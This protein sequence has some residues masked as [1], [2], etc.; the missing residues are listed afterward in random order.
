[1]AKRNLISLD[2]SSG[3]IAMRLSDTPSSGWYF[4]P[5]QASVDVSSAST[6]H[7]PLE[8]AKGVAALTSF[9]PGGDSDVEDLRAVALALD[10]LLSATKPELAH[11]LTELLP[12][13]DFAERRARRR[14]EAENGG[15]RADSVSVRR[16]ALC[17]QFGVL[18]AMRV[19][20]VDASPTGDHGGV[21]DHALLFGRDMN[22]ARFQ[23][24]S[25]LAEAVA[26]AS[27]PL[28]S[29]AFPSFDAQAAQDWAVLVEACLARPST[30][31][32]KDTLQRLASS[33]DALGKSRGARAAIA[34]LLSANASLATAYATTFCFLL[35]PLLTIMSDSSK[36]DFGEI[37]ATASPPSLNELV[38]RFVSQRTILLFEHHYSFGA[39]ARMLFFRLVQGVKRPR[40]RV[41]LKWVRSFHAV[42]LDLSWRRSLLTFSERSALKDNSGGCGDAFLAL[43][44]RVAARLT[45]VEA[46]DSAPV[47]D[48]M[49]FVTSISS[50]L[51]LGLICVGSDVQIATSESN[52]VALSDSIYPLLAT[53]LD[54]FLASLALQ[55]L[56]ASVSSASGFGAASGFER[57]STRPL[58]EFPSLQSKS[59][60]LLSRTLQL[61]GAKE[62]LGQRALQLKGRLSESLS[63]LPANVD[64]LL[65]AAAYAPDIVGAG[66]G[67]VAAAGAAIEESGRADES[68]EGSRLSRSV[69]DAC[70]IIRRV[71]I[72]FSGQGGGG[73]DF[74]PPEKI[75]FNDYLFDTTR[76]SCK[77]Q[78]RPEREDVSLVPDDA[79]ID[80]LWQPISSIG[81][82]KVVVAR[83]IFEIL[84]DSD[85]PH[86]HSASEASDRRQF[87]LYVAHPLSS[88]DVRS[89]STALLILR[90]FL[91]DADTVKDLELR[92]DEARV[93]LHEARKRATFGEADYLQSI[94]VSARN[95]YALDATLLAYAL[96]ARTLRQSDV[97]LL[98][99]H[100]V[101]S[102][103]LGEESGINGSRSAEAVCMALAW[104]LQGIE[105]VGLS[106]TQSRTDHCFGET[107]WAVSS[108]SD[109]SIPFKTSRAANEFK[110]L[111]G[112]SGQSVCGQ[113]SSRPSLH[114]LGQTLLSCHDFVKVLHGPHSSF[115]T[116]VR[117]EAQLLLSGLSHPAVSA[118]VIHSFKSLLASPEFL[119]ASAEAASVGGAG[120]GATLLADRLPPI[121]RSASALA[122]RFPAQLSC[123][124]LS[125]ARVALLLLFPPRSSGGINCVRHVT[126]TSSAAVLNFG[127]SPPLLTNYKPSVSLSAPIEAVADLLSDLVILAGAGVTSEVNSSSSG[128][129]TFGVSVVRFV[130]IVCARNGGEAGK[131][132]AR[133]VLTRLALCLHCLPMMSDAST[134]R[135]SQLSPT[136]SGWRDSRVT[137]LAPRQS[138]AVARAM[139]S[140]TPSVSLELSAALCELVVEALAASERAFEI[141][142]AALKSRGRESIVEGAS[143][144]PPSTKLRALLSD[145]S[146]HAQGMDGEGAICA[147]TSVNGS[148]SL[149]SSLR[150]LLDSIEDC[151]RLRRGML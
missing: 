90:D 87:S 146:L 100:L 73:G 71:S 122:Q 149:I 89:V 150:T 76:D 37:A 33:S 130:A 85:S 19:E 21:F 147:N 41:S 47:A 151:L 144:E 9:C 20:L 32:E 93:E 107:Q 140:C 114:A 31:H 86:H 48:D 42:L 40:G 49:R 148:T 125:L 53:E 94:A 131:D 1:M 2:L 142:P 56:S 36:I 118:G 29:N 57:I 22:D 24:D 126:D 11:L 39:G 64:A 23:N 13:A 35:L 92:R 81:Q 51:I 52:M 5:R 138:S 108:L 78:L 84:R 50:K 115:S 141:A 98:L 111:G 3:W 112:V 137:M 116:I 58:S 34:V 128:N 38:A 105:G 145:I 88:D 10:A 72:S 110:N 61:C 91:F 117:A 82:A 17:S 106:Q 59:L 4:Y 44:A 16:A 79:P 95:A 134:H 43:A 6:R 70:A 14:R 135:E 25:N 96:A 60:W 26:A 67:K 80:N 136:K 8:A 83:D 30:L 69:F 143:T 129:G 27:P 77:Q 74:F 124:A 99:L 102:P 28:L 127:P 54:A 103:S 62:S 133:R 66:S 120:A 104:A 18:S 46:C 45:Q 63:L 7:L 97:L 55:N 113:A 65:E 121:M 75:L 15:G 139:S 12:E 109:P 101:F 132:V 68:W 119:G 123:P